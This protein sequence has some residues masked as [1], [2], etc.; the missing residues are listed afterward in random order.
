[1]D[2]EGRILAWNRALE[3]MYGLGRAEAIGRRLAEVFPLHVARRVQHESSYNLRPEGARIFR[4]SMT[5]RKGERLHV[6][7]AI[8]PAEEAGGGDG[9]RVVSLDDVT[10]LVKLEEQML[11]QERLAALG[12]LAAGV[13]HEINTPLTGIVSY[14]QLLLERGQGQDQGRGREMLEKI[15]GQARRAS[16]IANS[17]LDLARPERTTFG[18]VDVN[19]AIQE[20]LHLFRP[21]IRGAGIELQAIL[22]CG[23]PPILGHR[24]KLQQV[25]LNLLLNARDA[26][27]GGGSV[28]V[29]TRH[30]SEGIVLEVSDDGAGISD[31]DLPRIFDPFFTTKSRGKGTGLGLSICY[32]IVQEHRGRIHVQSSP[33]ERTRF[34]VELPSAV[35]EAHEGLG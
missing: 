13:A 8:S 9:A 25:V 34:S 7:L 22:E 21:Q 1:M 4:L 29:E 30:G 26:V 35:R 32:G 10:G 24:G 23:L 17:L 14:A 16:R 6:N 5:N 12:L 3:E 20:I 19:E 27:G 15:D 28:R 31:D 33:G 11:Q 18:P 2:G